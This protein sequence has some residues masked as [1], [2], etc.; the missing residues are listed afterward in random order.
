MI[1]PNCH[2]DSDLTPPPIAPPLT[3]CRNCGRTLVVLNGSARLAMA[4]DTI[5]L[6]DDQKIA[7][8]KLR[9]VR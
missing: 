2:K 1:C 3:V 7:F 9:P 4:E 6:S 8:R 5:H